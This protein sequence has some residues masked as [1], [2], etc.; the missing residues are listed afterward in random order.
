MPS[1]RS[2]CRLGVATIA[3]VVFALLP[4][5]ASALGESAPVGSG[6]TVV[7]SVTR[8]GTAGA[9]AGLC[10]SRLQCF[11]AAVILAAAAT[12]PLVENAALVQINVAEPDQD[13]N[14]KLAGKQLLIAP[15]ADPNINLKADYAEAV[16]KLSL[17][18]GT[19]Y[20]CALQAAKRSFDAGARS[21]SDKVI[22]LVA[23]RTNTF[24][25]TG[26]T[27]SGSPTG[28]PPMT[29]EQM[30][31]QFDSRTVIRAFAVGPDVTCA[32]DP[33]GHGSLSEAA[34]VT[35]GGTCTP[36]SSFEG[37]SAILIEAVLGGGAP[38]PPPPPPPPPLPPSP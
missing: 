25:S 11:K 21:G 4:T 6:K 12:A 8:S 19:C 30:A 16:N 13:V 31:G 33:L 2:L 35:P 36:V 22:L 18:G 10:G 24:A 3:T 38:P 9:T 32:A 26:F 23:E 27:S 7:F 37:L 15:D 20:T 5:A 17:G 28:Y 29:L 14:M 1:K 34:A